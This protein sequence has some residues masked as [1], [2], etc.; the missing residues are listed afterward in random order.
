[1]GT[2]LREVIMDIGG[3]IKNGKNF[4]AV[5]IGGPSAAA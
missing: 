1:M 4:K 2:T 3:G 5:Q